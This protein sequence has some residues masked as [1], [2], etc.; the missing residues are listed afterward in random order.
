MGRLVLA[1]SSHFGT[2]VT[3]I[4][5]SWRRGFYSLMTGF[6]TLITA[7]TSL[8][9]RLVRVSSVSPLSSNIGELEITGCSGAQDGQEGAVLFTGLYLLA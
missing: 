9:C 1:P 2:L 7:G 5:A 4:V 3:R 6:Y 8:Q